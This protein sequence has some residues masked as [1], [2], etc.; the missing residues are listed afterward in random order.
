MTNSPVQGIHRN[1][2][3]CAGM[4]ACA[5]L[6]GGIVRVAAEETGDEK[7]AAV[8]AQGRQA[9]DTDAPSEPP[10]SRGP[11]PLRLHLRDG[12][13]IVAK[14][15]EDRFEMQTAY[16]KLS[17][18]WSD[19]LRVRI[20]ART[21][22]EEAKAIAAL[23]GS[24]GDP[25]FKERQ[26]AQEKI[27]AYGGK[28]AALLTEALGKTEDLEAK[29]RIQELLKA[30]V[31]TNGVEPGSD[32]LAARHLRAA[33]RILPDLL[34]V[35]TAHG[36]LK[37]KTAEIESVE[38]GALVVAY[39]ESFESGLGGW[40]PEQAGETK[41]H[42]SASRSS[43]GRNALRCSV[44]GL[45][46]YENATSCSITSPKINLQGLTNP[47][48]SYRFLNPIND[49]SDRFT[50]DLSS[51]GGEHWVEVSR[52]YNSGG[53]EE[54]T[55]NLRELGG[56]T[57]RIRFNFRSDEQTTYDGVLVDQIVVR[58]GEDDW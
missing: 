55:I 21:S 20:G 52:H 6:A 11:Q 32:R 54:E 14:A 23:I 44:P 3:W 9:N 10:A 36:R 7:P 25:E 41:W 28:A 27:L 19:V 53:W 50:V 4:A 47:V 26:A 29:K 8:R 56:N 42:L 18:S 39:K 37:V 5:L 15:V 43:D 2:R 58:E 38:G 57:L 34:E 33:G 30:I 45:D 51:D 12:S 13:L 16:G 49:S 35:E 22:S 17:A 46:R 1:I 48:L 24:L 40:M 31:V